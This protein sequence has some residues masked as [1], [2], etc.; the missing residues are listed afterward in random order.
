MFFII[1]GRHGFF[2]LFLGLPVGCLFR[3]IFLDE[4]FF[5]DLLFL[6]DFLYILFGFLKLVL[7]LRKHGNRG[8]DQGK[9]KKE[10]QSPAKQGNRFKENRLCD[11]RETCVHGWR[12]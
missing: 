6:F 12:T 8:Q 5:F 3:C 4:F 11:M 9:E 10:G 2:R 7:I 1:G